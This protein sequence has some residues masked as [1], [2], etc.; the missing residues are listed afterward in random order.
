M[1]AKHVEYVSGVGIDL[2]KF[3]NGL[4]QSLEKSHK[5]RVELN[6][7][8]DA[9]LLLSVGELNI[10]K[11]HSIVINAISEIKNDNIYYAIAREGTLKEV[12]IQLATDKSIVSVHGKVISDI[13]LDSGDNLI[14]FL[15]DN[16]ELNSFIDYPVLG[17]SVDYKKYIDNEFIIAIGN[18]DI[19]EQIVSKMTGA[20]F[21]HLFI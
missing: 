13:V 6:I 18:S 14:G 21:I 20:K 9:Y 7:P 10:N 1:H 3:G 8:D 16:T 11:K 2:N 5:I 4:V 12:L 15:D 17:T 19:R